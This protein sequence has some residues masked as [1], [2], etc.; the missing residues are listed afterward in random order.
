LSI[1]LIAVGSCPE[2]L[3]SIPHSRLLSDTFKRGTLFASAQDTAFQ[4]INRFIPSLLCFRVP[5][6]L[7]LEFDAH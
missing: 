3:E 6:I 4:I 2:S 1:A 5:E 7:T